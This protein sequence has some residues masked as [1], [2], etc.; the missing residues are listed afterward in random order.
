MTPTPKRQTLFL[1][2]NE[3]G[4]GKKEKKNRKATWH[5]ITPD[6]RDKEADDVPTAV[7]RGKEREKGLLLFTGVR[8]EGFSF[9]VRR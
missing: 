1:L 7:S 8:N 6:M 5:M 9:Q 2:G 4:I 3:A